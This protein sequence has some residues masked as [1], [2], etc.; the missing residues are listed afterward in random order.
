M[1]NILHYGL[2]RSGTNIL[3]AQLNSNFKVNILNN[4]H[5]RN[6]ALHKHFRLYDEKQ[7]IPD[8]QFYNELT[9][10]HFKEYE[11][12]FGLNYKVD[13]IFVV[14]KDPYSWYISYLNWAKKCNWPDVSYHYIEE[15]NKFYGKWLEFAEDDKRISF[16]KYIDLLTQTKELLKQFKNNQKLPLK[17][18][19][20]VFGLSYQIKK[21]NESDNF[22]GS[23]LKYYEEKKYLEKL[24][25]LEIEL[26]NAK[27]DKQLMKKLGYEIENPK[28]VS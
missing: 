1:K 22:T 3:E 18:I 26:I 15:Y 24:S 21:V 12:S 10:K 11:K 25:D 28:L 7:F 20:K 5:L 8:P 9:F 17:L 14:S 27:I 19:R 16:I 23:N 4:N 13:A 6:H 2:Q